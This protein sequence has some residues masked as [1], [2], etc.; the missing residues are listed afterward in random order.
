MPT[1]VFLQSQELMMIDDLL[2]AM[3]GVDGK[4]VRVQQGRT[5]NYSFVFRVDTKLNPSL[6]V[7]T[8]CLC[9]D[10]TLVPCF[11]IWTLRCDC[12]KD[13]GMIVTINLRFRCKC[14][15]TGSFKEDHPFV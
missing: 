8:L 10:K 5:H 1:E 6:H 13:V 9:M 15:I 7:C 2:Y 12:I 4:Y 3:V 11:H 14:W